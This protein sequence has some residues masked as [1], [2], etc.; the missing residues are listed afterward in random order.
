MANVQTLQEKVQK[1]TEKVEKCKGTIVRHEKSLDKKITA[2]EKKGINLRGL[3]KDEIEKVREHHRS[4]DSSWEIYEV[5]SKFEDIKGAT[6]KLRDAEIVLGNWQSKLDVEIEKE[7]FLND[8]APKVIKDFL[9]SWKQMAYDWHIKKY[10]AYQIFKKDLA[11]KVKEA[12]AELGVKEGYSTSREQDKAL[13][14]QGLDYRSI[15]A[16]KAHFAGGAVLYMDGIRNE[17]E[18]L[19]WL[20]KELENEKKAKMLDLINRINAVVGTITD[21][22]FLRVS[23]KGNLDGYI[24]GEKGKAKVETIGAGGYAVQVFHYRTLVNKIK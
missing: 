22:S 4:T 16:K 11:E 2:L 15:E 7:R 9:E 18:R 14:E 6:R 8:N 10:N 5:T 12:K 21:A 24:I 13:K 17:V 20:E 23:E 1:A 3:N 19:A